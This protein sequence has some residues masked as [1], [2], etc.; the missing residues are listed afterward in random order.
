MSEEQLTHQQEL[1][2]VDFHTRKSLEKFATLNKRLKFIQVT[3]VTVRTNAPTPEKVVY[4]W[5]KPFNIF[6]GRKK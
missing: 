1:D 3:T 6:K 5:A 2:L 4:W